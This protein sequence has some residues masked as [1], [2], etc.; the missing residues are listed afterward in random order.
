[1]L[2][3]ELLAEN[4]PPEDCIRREDAERVARLAM[5]IAQRVLARTMLSPSAP[6]F[7]APTRAMAPWEARPPEE[8]ARMVAGVVRIVQAMILLGLIESGDVEASVE[9]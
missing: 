4:P 6:G 2:R 9:S 3:D 7:S 5:L 1:M 8:R